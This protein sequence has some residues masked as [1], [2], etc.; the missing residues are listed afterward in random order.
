M[1]GKS[2]VFAVDALKLYIGSRDIAPF[3]NFALDGGEWSASCSGEP[4]TVQSAV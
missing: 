1:K 2:K 4:Q 3:L